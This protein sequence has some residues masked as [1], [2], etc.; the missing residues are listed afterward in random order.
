MDTKPQET[1]TKLDVWR[2]ESDRVPLDQALS[3]E[4]DLT[5]E[6]NKRQ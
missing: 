1:S 4:E 5:H 3:P 2:E 6:S